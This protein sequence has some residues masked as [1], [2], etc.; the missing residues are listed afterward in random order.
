MNTSTEYIP[1]G[2]DSSNFFLIFS[3]ACAVFAFGAFTPTYWLQWPAG[4][5]IGSPLLHLHAILFSLWV[6]LLVWQASLAARGRSRSHRAWG[7]AGVALASL[8]VAVGSAVAIDE[9]RS[10][11]A[12]GYAD[13]ARAFF[14][15]PS[16]AIVL[17]VGFFA[18]AMF[19]IRRPE[20]HKRLMLLATIT[21]LQAAAARIF[22]L[23]KV[24]TAPG[25]RPGLGPPPPV[26]VGVYPSLCLEILVLAGIVY[27]WR[28]RGRPH[29]SWVLGFVILGLEI[30]A[31][32]MLANTPDWQ[33]LAGMAAHI[34]DSGR[35]GAPGQTVDQALHGLKENPMDKGHVPERNVRSVSEISRR[36]PASR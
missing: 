5:F 32:P 7:I 14:I 26:A 16:S 4:T 28:T 19:S 1:R 18:A 34:V 6:V 17:F 35:L 11:L 31:R 9:L 21:L 15:V 36:A 2:T 24:G 12:S 13:R 23:L 10:G 30:A 27:D 22:L 8:M 33:A 20:T 29:L 25:L 3:T